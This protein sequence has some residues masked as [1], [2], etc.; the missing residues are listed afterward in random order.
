MLAV[1]V[2]A[3]LS[4][5]IQRVGPHFWPELLQRLFAA[6]LVADEFAAT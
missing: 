2:I 5:A 4:M 6:L 3:K 1:E